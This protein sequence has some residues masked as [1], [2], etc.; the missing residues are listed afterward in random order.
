MPSRLL[1]AWLSTS[2]ILA[3][4][5]AAPSP[6]RA[7]LAVDL[8]S[9]AGAFWR[10]GAIAAS[11]KPAQAEPP[12]AEPPKEEEGGAENARTPGMCVVPRE[13]PAVACKPG[14]GFLCVSTPPGGVAGGEL[15]LRGTI[16][17]KNSVLASIRIAVQ[18]EYTK[19]SQRVDT[20][21][22]HD[23]DCR[24]APP[25][26]KPFCLDAEGY[27][28]ARVPLSSTGPHTIS[29]SASR[30]S[31]GS[32]EKRVRTSRVGPL[33]MEGSNLAFDPDVRTTPRAEGTHVTVVA[34]LLGECQF[35]DHIGASTGGV[36]V[37][38]E[39]VMTDSAGNVRRISCPTS[40]EQGG[41]GRFVVGVPLFAGRNTL[42]IQA[43]NAAVEGKGCPRVE[44]I[45]FEASG[46]ERSLKIISP[47]PAPAY[48]SPSSSFRWRFSLGEKAGC[49]E[50]R[51]NR[52][53]PEELCPDEEGT[54][55]AL[56]RPR[57]GIN[58]AALALPEGGGNFAWTFGWGHIISPHRNEGR[59]EIPRALRAAL[60]AATVNGILLPL[61]N[62]FLA[63]DERSAL[64]KELAG[65]DAS[66]SAP[67][68]P[69]E[70]EG[71]AVAIPKCSSTSSFGGYAFGLRGQ[72]E[73]ASAVVEEARFSDGRVDL[74][75]VVKDARFGIDLA[76]DTN[77]DG[78]GDRE[79][80]PLVIAFRKAI[81]ELALEAKRDEE[82]RPLILL[83]SP[84][85]D[86]SFKPGSYCSGMPAILVPKNFV[87]GATEWGSF[88]SCDVNL[89]KGEAVEVCQA[90][91]SLNAQTGVLAEK[92]L[93][94]VNGALYCGGSS[95]LTG[96]ARRG[97]DAGIELGCAAGE[98]CDG[99]AAILPQLHLPL[100]VLLSDG[101]EISSSGIQGSASLV[102]GAADLYAATPPPFRIP[103]AGVITRADVGAKPF[104]SAFP[105]FGDMALSASL[106][107]A[108]A[109]LFMATVAGDGRQAKGILDL[110]VDEDFFRKFDVDFVRLCDRSKSSSSSSSSGSPSDEEDPLKMLCYVRPRV[111]ELLGTALST[112]GYFSPNQ[113]LLMAV[114]A[115][116]AL[117][118]R[119]SVRDL[120]ELPVVAA[121][122]AGAK[123]AKE[124]K[125]TDADEEIPAGHLLEFEVGGLGLAFYAL[126]VDEGA[127]ADEFGNLPVKRGADGRPVI[128]SMR[129]DRADPW[130]GPIVRFD[131]TLLVAL[132][133][134]M[135][136]PH[137][138]DPEA[139]AIPV[140]FLADRSRL[141]IVPVEGTNATT[142]PAAGLISSLAE[143]LQLAIA[144]MKVDLPVPREIA[145]SKAGDGS[146]MSKL[147]LS[148]ISI[149][150]EG[151][152]LDSDAVTN[153]LTLAIEAAVAQVLHQG[154]KEVAHRVPNAK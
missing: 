71:P 129:P 28:S 48:D 131:L 98:G 3:G 70:E 153:S 139:F 5:C 6:A 79:P 134:G 149:G 147:G 45:S 128:R 118:P 87:G 31:G 111:G 72:P 116:R 100:T 61:V 121:V 32:V 66:V 2:M 25:E 76:P 94:A 62:Q 39:N 52:S 152:H 145:L 74:R 15:I 126:E 115:N 151:I 124:T 82:G 101:L 16:D 133:V 112:Y 46:S 89:A 53:N 58:V 150:P 19:K 142:V 140:R 141:V 36:K 96:L 132:E 8:F 37:T 130:E 122:E 81:A 97:T 75:A 11:S 34:T 99:I 83:S 23:G 44:G 14:D 143:K 113:P 110:D 47:S 117:S 114:R 64:F 18:H 88:V 26:G 106:D 50:L 12:P 10:A 93:D 137:P 78:K 4:V 95:A 35:C 108:N 40:V 125:G 103:Q 102:A 144:G 148:A 33:A 21:E 65:G 42:A 59:I 136:G 68:S 9:R 54:F 30:L 80:V 85:D 24:T 90:I 38:V 123:G 1:V 91:N 55:S 17:R 105:A 119:L 41:Q 127:P 13:P 146:L 60:P 77:G 92:I 69:A 84:H 104:G 56:L 135:P 49:V 67:S 20:A 63:S 107:A 22:P 7:G 73:V 57:T 154:G 51:F 27:F 120:E 109:L 29:L 138:T 43:C 86:C